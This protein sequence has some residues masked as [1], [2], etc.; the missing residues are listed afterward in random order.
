[1]D[2]RVKALSYS[3]PAVDL[4]A[5]EWSQW[6][7][8]IVRERPL[9]ALAKMWRA[10]LEFLGVGKRGALLEETIERTLVRTLFGA[11][12]SAGTGELP[13]EVRYGR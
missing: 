2:V 1:L 12:A 11:M 9:R 5:E 3:I 7:K 8:R 10:A 13:V 6:S 4:T